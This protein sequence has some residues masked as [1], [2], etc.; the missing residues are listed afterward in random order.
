MAYCYLW[1]AKRP[2]AIYLDE[3]VIGLAA[4][5]KEEEPGVYDILTMMLDERYQGLGLG[6]KAFEVLLDLLKSKPDCRRITLNFKPDNSR[7]EKFYQSFGFQRTGER[8]NDEIV[9][10]C[11]V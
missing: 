2:L 8:F 3:E 9:M 5:E 4:Y 6:K 7:A 1:P 11:N 10:A